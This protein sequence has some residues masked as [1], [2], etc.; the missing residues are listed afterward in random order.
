[1]TNVIAKMRSLAPAFVCA[2]LLGGCAAALVPETSDPWKTF[3][4]ACALL[5]AGRPLP[6]YRMLRESMAAFER[7]DEPLRLAAVQLQY[8]HLLGSIGF[9]YSKGFKRHRDEMGGREAVRAK[10]RALN[11]DA[12]S[13]LVKALALPSTQA[14]AVERTQAYL[15]LIEAHE[16][17][18]EYREACSAV[19]RAA[20][21]YRQAQGV[22]HRYMMYPP[23]N[24]PEHLRLRR[25]ALECG[26]AAPRATS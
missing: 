24:V 16:R 15:M 9:L 12:K 18:E 26:A 10:V 19:E 3:T 4:N 17:L 8:A 6:A 25:E 5:D 14:S 2:A 7:S 23:G 13:N 11:V 1:M 22:D 20:E 21:S